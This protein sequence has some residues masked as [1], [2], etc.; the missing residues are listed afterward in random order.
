MILILLV[1]Y[2]LCTVVMVVSIGKLYVPS[3]I[4]TVI[5]QNVLIA[6]LLK[7]YLN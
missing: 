2:G 1:L 7:V 3:L 4:A 5:V 6:F